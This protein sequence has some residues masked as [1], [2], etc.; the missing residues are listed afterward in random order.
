MK[1]MHIAPYFHEGFGY[2]ENWLPVHQKRMGHEVLIVS[3]DWYFPFPDYSS[4]MQNT[5]GDRFVGVGKS[6]HN[7]IT[8]VR[9]KSVFANQQRPG[10]I[11]FSVLS[12]LKDFL[13]DVV[14]VHGAT[15][16]TLLETLFFR[17]KF[18]YKVF[19]DSHQDVSVE[20]KTGALAKFTWYF[21]WRISYHYL[22]LKQS[23][24]KFLPITSGAQTWLQTKLRIAAED[25]VISPLGVD[26][27]SMSYLV[28]LDYEFRKKNGLDAKTII[29]N[30]GKQYSGK[31]IEWIIDVA[32]RCHRENSNIF[33][34]LVGSA[35]EAYDVLIKKRLEVLGE[36]NFLRFPFL[37]L[38]KLHAVFCAADIG[39]WPGVPSNSIQD[40][41]ACEVAL[42]VPD[43]DIV[44]HLVEGNGLKES[45]DCRKAA[46]FIGKLARDSDQLKSCKK[47]SAELVANFGWDKVARELTTVYQDC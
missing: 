15:N 38:N 39:I 9:K 3:S 2:Q 5:L 32:I 46:D 26:L 43:D 40:A 42:I 11:L 35:D 24:A 22:G 28:S 37:D 23:V 41:M 31:K 16:L 14:H 13:P 6:F 8:V 10:I 1:I 7:G 29:V 20:G 36:Q 30:S 19:V 21:F 34:I 25:T 27:D 18:S 4:V 45:Q 47:K 44:G 12:E 17:K 33:L